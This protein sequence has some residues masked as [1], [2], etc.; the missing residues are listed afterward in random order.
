MP[1]SQPRFSPVAHYKNVAE[2]R[3]RLAEL[4][5]TLP[6]DDSI[7]SASDGS[8]LAQPLEVAGFTGQSGHTGVRQCSVPKAKS[9][10]GSLPERSAARTTYRVGIW[11]RHGNNTQL[12]LL[13]SAPRSDDGTKS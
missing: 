3:A 5:V 13:H 7:L 11:G 9:Q 8:P 12:L 6:V 10:G 1:K 2:L 4:G